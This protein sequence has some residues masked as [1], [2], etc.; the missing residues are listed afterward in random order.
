VNVVELRFDKEEGDKE[1]EMFRKECEKAA[2][3][4]EFGVDASALLVMS[5]L[6]L[7]LS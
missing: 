6:L 4:L 1:E 2:G 5:T 7:L 3:W